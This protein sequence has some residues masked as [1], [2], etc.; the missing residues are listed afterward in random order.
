M[1]LLLHILVAF[2]SVGFTAFAAAVPSLAKLRVAYVLA[3]TTLGTGVLLVVVEPKTMVQACISGMTYFVVIS[4][5][6]ALT[7]RQLAK[8]ASTSAS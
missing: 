2:I 1:I 4:V 3:G 8:K 7:R 6:I 5:I